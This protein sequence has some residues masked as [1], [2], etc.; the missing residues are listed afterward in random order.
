MSDIKDKEN[1]KEKY[2]KLFK[3]IRSSKTEINL[4]KIYEALLENQS[5]LLNNDIVPLQFSNDLIWFLCNNIINLKTQY[6]IFKLYIDSFFS[7]KA[8]PENLQKIFVLDQI[9]KYDSFIYKSTSKTDNVMKAYELFFDKYFPRK[10]GMIYKVGEVVDVFIIE[11][12]IGWVQMRIKKIDNNYIILDDSLNENREIKFPIDSY[13]IREK[14]SF[15]SEEEMNWR[16]SLQRGMKIDY[17]NNN[18]KLWVEANVLN[19]LCDNVVLLPL[20]NAQGDNEVENVYSPN[21]RPLNTFSFKY[22]ENE[23]QYFPFLSFNSYFS[24]FSYVL[25]EPKIVEGQETNFLLP[26]TYL[27]YHSFFFYDLFNYFINKLVH[28]KYLEESNEENLTIEYIFKILDT[29]NRGL[30]IVNQLFL[31]QYF[32]DHMLPIIKTVLLKTSKDKKKNI[33]LQMFNKIIEVLGKIGFMSDY[34]F[35]QPKLFLEFYLN[36]GF[37][38]FKESENLEKRI[39]GLNSILIALKTMEFFSSHNLP[40]EYNIIFFQTILTDDSDFF[41]LL[42]NKSDIHDQLILKGKEIVITLYKENLLDTKDINKLYNFAISSPEGTECYKQLYLI[43]TEISKDMPLE[44]SQNMLEKIISYPIDYIRREDIQLLFSLIEYIKNEKD[45]KKTI[46]EALD[47]IYKYITS[48]IIKGKNYVKDFTSTISSLIKNNDCLFFANHYLEK[49][50]NELLENKN[51]D[52]IEFFYD[53]LSYFIISFNTENKK[54]MKDKFCSILMTNNNSKKLLDNLIRSIENEKD[55]NKDEMYNEKETKH[56]ISILDSIQSILYYIEY[57]NFF[58]IDSIMVLCD[59]FIFGKNDNKKFLHFLDFLR[60]NELINIEEFCEQF[61]IKFDAFISEINKDN[62]YNYLM[63]GDEEFIETILNFYLTIN[64][65]INDLNK[66]DYIDEHCFEKKNPLNFKYFNVIWKM[67]TKIDNYNLMKDFLEVFSLRLFSPKERFEIWQAIIK[68]IFEEQDTFVEPKIALN[69]INDIITISEKFGTAGVIPHYLEKIKKIPIKLSICSKIIPFSDFDLTENIFTTSTLYDVKKEIQ[70]KLGIDPILIDFCKYQGGNTYSL[71]SDSKS[72]CYIF[73][74]ENTSTSSLSSLTKE[75]LERKYCL[76]MERSKELYS[77]KKF[78]LIDINN[79]NQFNQKTLSVFRAIFLK[80]TNGQDIMDKNSYLNY[81]N[82]STG[83]NNNYIDAQGNNIFER[84]DSDKK[85]FWVFDNFIEFYLDSFRENKHYSIFYNL[86]NFGYRNDLELLNTP[87]DKNCPVYYMENNVSEYMPRYFIGNDIDY[88]NKIFD[89]SKSNDKSVHELAQQIIS[90]LSTMTK[91]SNLFFEKNEKMIEDLLE[92]DNLEMRTYTFSI[93]LSELEKNKEID[94]KDIQSPINDFIKKFLGKIISNLNNYINEVNEEIIKNKYYNN[95]ENTQ[96]IQFLNYYH[97]IIQIIL[98]SLKRLIDNEELFGLRKKIESDLDIGNKEKVINN[99]ISTL[100]PNIKNQ[101]L[102]VLKKLNYEQIFNIVISYLTIQKEKI[103]FVVYDIGLSYDILNLVFVLLEIL[104]TD[105]INVKVKQKIYNNY[106]MN[107]FNLCK[108][109]IIRCKTLLES[110]NRFI[111]L[112]KQ[113]DKSYISLIKDEITKEILNYESLN[114]YLLS[115]N[116]IFSI[117]K[118]VINITFKKE[119]NYNNDKLFDIFKSILKI[120]TNQN[121]FL[122]DILITEYLEI[123]SLIITKLKE[124]NYN[125]LYE[126][127]FNDLLLLIITDYLI[128]SNNS[129]NKIYSRYNDSEYIDS[130]FGFIKNIISIEPNKYIFTFFNND[131]IKNLKTKHLSILSVDKLNYDPKT[132]IKN[133]M[134]YLGLKN[135]SSLCYMN[136]VIQQLYMIPIFRKSI[137]S[138]KIN[139]EIYKLNEK[140]DL[141]D[142]LFQLI[143]MFYYLTY[144]DRSYYDPKQFVFSFKDY[145]GNPTNP[146]LQCDAQEFLTRF[147]EKI[148]EKIKNTKERFLFD[149]ILGGTTLQQIICTNSECRNISERR[150]KIIYLS[151]D[152]KGNHTLEDCLD[153]FISEEKIE[154]YNCE[155]CNKKITNIKKVLIDKLPN[156]LIIHLQRISFNYETFLMEKINDDITFE[157]KLNI[158]KFT[159][160]KNNKDVDTEKYEYEYIGVIV[161]S[162]T[163]QSGHYYSIIQTNVENKIYK[164]NDTSVTEISYDNLQ[165][166]FISNNNRDFSPSPYMLLFQKKIKNPVIV[167]IREI[168][169]SNNILNLLKDKEINNLK[170]NGINY[171]VYKDEKEAIEKNMNNEINDKEII[172]RDNKVI[173]HLISYDNA[174]NYMDVI[175]KNNKE[176]NIPFKSMILEENIKLSND[177]KFFSYSFGDFIEH[178]TKM[179]Q[180]EIEIDL[181]FKK[182]ISVDYMP[183]IQIINDYLL[184]IFSICWNK[185][186]LKNII[187]NMILII[188]YIPNILHYLVKD[189]IE[190]KKEIILYDYLL[191]KDAKL[192]EAFSIYFGKIL[193][194]SLEKNIENETAV[195]LIDFYLEKIPVEISKKWMDMEYFNNFLYILVENSEKIKKKFLTEEILSK[196]IDYILGKESPIYKGDERNENNNIKGKF[197]PIVK[198]IALLYEYYINNKDKEQD[199]KIS[200]QDELMINHL[201]VYEKIIIDNCD[202]KSVSLLIKLKID[203]SLNANAPMDKETIDILVKLKIPSS[204]S[205]ENI[206]SSISLIDKILGIFNDKNEKEKKEIMSIIFG[207]PSIFVENEE[208]KFCYVSGGYFNY[209]SILHNIASHNEINDETIPLLLNIFKLI[210][211]Y[212]DL[213]NYISKMPAPNSFTYNYLEYLVKLYIEVKDK[214]S[215]NSEKIEDKKTYDE[216]N[217]LMTDFCKKYDINLEKVKNDKR[218]CI[219]HHMFIYKIKFD[220]MKDIKG[221]DSNILNTIK[222]Y[223]DKIKFFYLKFKYYLTENKNNFCFKFFSQKIDIQYHSSSESTSNLSNLNLSEY[224]LEGLFIQGVKDCKFSFSIEP[225]IS[226]A[227][228]VSIKKNEKYILFMKDYNI[229][230]NDDDNNN[231]DDILIDFDVSNLKINEVQNEN[232]ANSEVP[233]SNK[234]QTNEDAVIINCLICGSPNVIDEDNQN[235]NCTYCTASLL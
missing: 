221:L 65:L 57:K 70:K 142:L 210:F 120:I 225:Y 146:N 19:V 16:K 90:E 121:I 3:D 32:K 206:I 179:I 201:P 134:N 69:M 127:N 220:L 141:D 191:A 33:S 9:F 37:N 148:E 26:N 143:K 205:V 219:T 129:K 108:N 41:Q 159:V 169:D 153:K 138:L 53:F 116:Y 232:K 94:N 161:H 110:S 43:L 39:I 137:L 42:F 24:S 152:I 46:N 164:F 115:R 180:F 113:N 2:S 71:Q 235:Y 149:N 125:S 175:N 118:D 222:N 17:L 212:P 218:I 214:I 103:K 126:Y 29:L 47:Y 133:Y 208:A 20:G 1:P 156:I 109:P 160:D 176:E 217:T 202:E 60:R 155:K 31:R 139:D 88:I 185:D 198:S 64:H 104:D 56:I 12:I 35:R 234:I 130:L 49:I 75:Q 76:I 131:D 59:I 194:L 38:C 147:V 167:N 13:Q 150:E 6:E 184:N 186:Y 58:T 21:I 80:V 163:A 106:I 62:Y 165:R 11:K 190:P 54:I 174:V 168:T 154:D 182:T 86:S 101:N 92:K 84:Y 5:D 172:L 170:D 77:M 192:G 151:V 187:N 18:K 136:S 66:I 34:A 14:N 55:K 157:P 132:E 100:I 199:L 10:Q 197:G 27:T 158:K 78:N 196:L 230:V 81:Y 87:L 166:E 93:I 105:E 15:V 91:M 8:K 228:E 83:S 207:I 96:F 135:L 85:G 107:I 211:K 114:E 229:F 122:L 195:K 189:I 231:N 95:K 226:N 30:E 112:L 73:N 45:Y 216:L 224:S 140:N 99:V 48:D 72:L 204:K 63:L 67:F 61:F 183:I 51:L 40:N 79:P 162:G 111:L 74:L 215:T 23:K 173:G 36:F 144:S 233:E 4:Q 97:I 98:F 22:E 177:K 50:I 213:Y 223:E 25:P 124:A 102:L 193:S 128:I 117:F 188:N 68:K 52:E 7:F 203:S 171:D 181:E 209:Y 82:Q 227:M 28:G 145:K 44:V 178:I 89:L 119:D 200:E 123:L